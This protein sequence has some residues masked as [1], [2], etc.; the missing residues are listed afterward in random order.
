M[1]CTRKIEFDTGHRVIG[2][3]FKCK[4]LHGHRYVLEITATAKNLDELGMVTDFATL[5]AIM[6]GWIDQ[7]W[8]HNVILHE[9][10]RDFG[11]YIAGYTGQK[12]YYLS[13]NPT[14]ENMLLHLKNEIIPVLFAEQNF[15]IIGLKLYETPNCHV[16]I[17]WVGG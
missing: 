11:E 12:V 13:N 2:H 14:A 16:V 15:A 1:K 3:Q 8:D 5:K 6:K 10:D 4:Y 17:E 7:Y 9:A